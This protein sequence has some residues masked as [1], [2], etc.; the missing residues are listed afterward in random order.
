MKPVIEIFLAAMVSVLLSLYPEVARSTPLECSILEV[1][2]NM[3]NVDTAVA[4]MPEVTVTGIIKCNQKPKF[5]MRVYFDMGSY[6]DNNFW[7]R[8]KRTHPQGEEK[9]YYG[10]YRED[11]VYLQEF[12]DGTSNY[13]EIHP[14]DTGCLSWGDYW[15]CTYRVRGKVVYWGWPD[16]YTGSYYD[17]GMVRLRYLSDE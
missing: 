15:Q 8:M 14:D 9:V 2:I 3:G 16:Y 10:L 7:R 6:R 17:H 4:Q 12:W 11:G 13:I 1:N 5:F